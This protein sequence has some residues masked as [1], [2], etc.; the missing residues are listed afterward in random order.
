MYS[1]EAVRTLS[2]ETPDGFGRLDEALA[3]WIGRLHTE[4]ALADADGYYDA[5]VY[6]QGFL[7]IARGLRAA[8]GR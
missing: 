8:A 1:A 6:A 4:L 5:K 3:D 2:G 7:E